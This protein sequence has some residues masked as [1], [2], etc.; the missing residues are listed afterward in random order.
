MAMIIDIDIDINIEEKAYANLYH[1]N[2]YSEIYICNLFVKEDCRG[3]GYGNK[4]L[5]KALALSKKLGYERIYLW[6]E[7]DS[8][9]QKWYEKKGFRIIQNRYYFKDKR[10]IWMCLDKRKSV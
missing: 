8:W 10:C 1:Y 3:K 5:R 4:I 9:L 7:K 2:G 6:A